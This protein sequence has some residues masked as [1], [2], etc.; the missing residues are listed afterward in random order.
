[1]GYL[2]VEPGLDRMFVVALLFVVYASI[3]YAV[4][5]RLCLRMLRWT[6]GTGRH[7]LV[8]RRC[9]EPRAIT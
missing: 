5:D 7:V 1:M 8:G 4:F 9:G 3:R 6:P 2:K